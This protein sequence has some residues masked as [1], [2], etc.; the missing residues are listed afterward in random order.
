MI[1]KKNLEKRTFRGIIMWKDIIVEEVR[2][3]R[4]KILE[5]ADFNMKKVIEDIKKLELKHKNRLIIKPFK[6]S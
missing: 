4:E 1:H 3:N 6:R 5:D 2:K